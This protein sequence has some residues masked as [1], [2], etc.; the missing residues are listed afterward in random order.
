MLGAGDELGYGRYPATAYAFSR[1][2][3]VP[4]RCWCVPLQH[5]HPQPFTRVRMWRHICHTRVRPSF[6]NFHRSYDK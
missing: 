6:N 5:Q 3:I 4:G 1:S 2:L